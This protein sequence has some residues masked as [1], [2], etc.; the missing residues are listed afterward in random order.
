MLF[1]NAYPQVYLEGYGL[2]QYL[3]GRPLVSIRG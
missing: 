2:R 1:D 3:E